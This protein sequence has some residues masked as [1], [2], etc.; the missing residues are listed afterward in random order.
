MRTH[1][2]RY[3]FIMN[4]IMTLVSIIFPLIT[5]PYITRV[6][7]VEGTGKISFAMSVVNYFTM[8]ATLGIPTYGIRIC[9]Q[10]RDDKEKLSTTVQE[11]LIISGI[12]TVMTY[13]VF[14]ATLFVIPNFA[15][16]K[17]VLM[18]I[19]VS[20][21]LSTIGVQWF[22]SALE[23]YSYITACSVIFKLIGIL[24][25]FAFVR[26]KEDYVIYGA[27][28]VI[29][30]FGSYIL[31]FFRLRKFISFRKYGTYNFK[32][33]LKAI[34]VFFAMSVGA[35]I[36]L[37]LDIVMLGFMKGDTATGYYN[38]SIKVKT[39]LVTCVTSLGTVLL[40]R[41]SYYVE[42]NEK[43]A[44]NKMVAKA[45]NFSFV[46]A[47]GVMVYFAIF[48]KESILLLSGE[49]FLPAT[50]PMIILMPTVLLIGLSNITGIQVLTPLGEE[51]KVMYS[52]L[53]GAVLNFLLNLVLIPKMGPTGAA[54]STTLAEILVL[55]VQAVFLNEIL[56]DIIGDL[57]VRKILGGLIPA[58]VIAL[59]FKHYVDMQVFPTLLLSSIL[60]FGA[61]GVLLLWMKEPFVI[62]VLDMFKN[63]I[64]R[65]KE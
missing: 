33:H 39:V 11:L 2:V 14:F 6:L 20:I 21:G 10:V 34:V 18:V 3:N 46:V 48:A 28:Y 51:K 26:D 35:S 52:I 59:I 16:R 38:A 31:N 25:M 5:F 37:N 23:Q 9:A 58:S 55:I 54:I 13:L 12:T 1:S 60:F 57:C 41:L 19:G 29:G 40:P 47:S 49:P 65:R 22:Y 7:L 64:H 36:Y 42:K 15:E 53:A 30:N 8:F 45:F 43:A 32:K 44:F 27:I 62:S 50:I 61:Y 4:S 56:K 17:T 24:L 63:W